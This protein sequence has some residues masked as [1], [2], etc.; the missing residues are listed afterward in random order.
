MFLIIKTTYLRTQIASLDGWTCKFPSKNLNMCQ[1][2]WKSNIYQINA[3]E[4]EYWENT[5][6][7]YIESEEKK[8]LKIY[9][10]A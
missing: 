9:C 3:K 5:W 6:R 7:K 10:Y 2:C 8:F 1:K 4:K